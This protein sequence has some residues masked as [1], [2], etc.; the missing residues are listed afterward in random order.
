MLALAV[1]WPALRGQFVWDDTL[2]IDRNPL[3]KGE[4]GL[5]SVWFQTD[6]PL[7][8]IGFWVQWLAW[9]KNPAGYHAVNVILHATSAVLVWRVLAR[10]KIAGP[11]LAATLFAVHPVCVA[12][13]AWISELKN[14]LS[15]PF[16]LLS[17]WWYLRAE[18]QEGAEGGRRRS[19]V[20]GQRPE[21][22]CQRSEIRPPT[23]DLRP[24]A[25]PLRVGT[26]C[27]WRHSCWRF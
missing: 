22:R 23:S 8:M 24:P 26:G 25:S 20:G 19:E 12:S 4:L 6:F 11:W 1:Y 2:L 15:L 9:G 13:V 27:R 18:G 10:L 3:V 7:T 16:F 5:R 21:V 17:L 14:T